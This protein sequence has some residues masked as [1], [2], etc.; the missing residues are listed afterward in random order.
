MWKNLINKQVAAAVIGALIVI[1][2]ALPW[3]TGVKYAC[4]GERLLG[5][6]ASVECEAP[7]K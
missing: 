1:F 4:L 3:A 2:S 6:P 5:E 7:A